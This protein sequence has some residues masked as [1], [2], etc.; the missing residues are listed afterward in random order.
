MIGNLVSIYT[1]GYSTGNMTN[2]EKKTQ[3]MDLN[4]QIGQGK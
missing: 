3:T 2:Q 4:D 1:N